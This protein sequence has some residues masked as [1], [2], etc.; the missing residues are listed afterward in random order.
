MRSIFAAL[1]IFLVVSVS[2]ALGYDGERKGFISSVGIGF[3]PMVKTSTSGGYFTSESDTKQG[4]FENIFAG[5][6]WD[7]QNMIVLTVEMY[8]IGGGD[9]YY[10]YGPAWYHY[11]KTSNKSL[12]AVAGLGGYIFN[13]F[14]ASELENGFGIHL[15]GGYEFIRHVQI[16]AQYTFAKTSSS[17]EDH[18]HNIL[19]LLISYVRF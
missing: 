17:Y 5:Y 6:A 19:S 12:Y 9:S 1:L 16:G 11:F 4:L 7:N 14:C 13:E 15:G 8:M 2:S 10:S 3:A 18:K